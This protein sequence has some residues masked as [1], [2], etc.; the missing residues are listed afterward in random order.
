MAWQRVHDARGL[1][2]ALADMRRMRDMSQEELAEWLGVDRTTVV[3]ME[4]GNLGVLSRFTAAL[5]IVGA[6]LVVVPRNAQVTVRTPSD[7]AESSGS[8]SSGR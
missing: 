6:E 7:S 3:R 8:D 5:A 1:A 4:S 2:R